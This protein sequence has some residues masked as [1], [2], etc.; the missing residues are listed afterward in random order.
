ML[1]NGITGGTVLPSALTPTTATG[2]L[3][4]Y[5]PGYAAASLSPAIMGPRD[6]FPPGTSRLRTEQGAHDKKPDLLGENCPP[7]H[8]APREAK[9]YAA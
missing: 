8:V 4:Q 2:Y 7:D 5:Y 6:Y 1:K 9:F 3:P